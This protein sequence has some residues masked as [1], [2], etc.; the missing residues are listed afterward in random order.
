MNPICNPPLPLAHAYIPNQPY[1]GLVPLEE[2]FRRGSMFPNLYQPW[3]KEKK[4][5]RG[6]LHANE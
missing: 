5:M 1:V 3:H 6:D 2:G 4:I